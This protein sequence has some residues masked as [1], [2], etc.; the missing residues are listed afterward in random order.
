MISL[1]LMSS[2]ALA[3]TKTEIIYDI[4]TEAIEAGI[5][6]DYAVAIATVES[7]LNPNAIGQLG[8]IGLFQLRPEF[9]DVRFGETTQNIRTAISYLRKIKEMWEPKIG[10]AWFVMYNCG[11]YR[12]PRAF[13]ETPER[14]QYYKKVMREL[15]RIKTERY[16]VMN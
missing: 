2:F 10:N 15:G 14:T 1:I 11:P 7:S 13:R 9:H 3:E 8:E 5:D 12:P 6:P 4:N 16:L